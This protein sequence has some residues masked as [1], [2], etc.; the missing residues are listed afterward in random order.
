MCS[1]LSALQTK[2]NTCGNSVDPDD[3]ARN[4]PSHQ[5]LHCLPSLFA[6]LLFFRLNPL[7]VSVDVQIQEWK[8]PFQKLRDLN[9]LFRLIT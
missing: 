1:P 3:T 4:E 8:S 2:T 6:I 7:F 5:D 9:Q